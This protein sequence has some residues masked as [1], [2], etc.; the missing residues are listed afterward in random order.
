M[1]QPV[2]RW[3]IMG[4]VGTRVWHKTWPDVQ[5]PTFR[6]CVGRVVPLGPQGEIMRVNFFVDG[7]AQERWTC[8]SATSIDGGGARAASRG[9]D[10]CTSALL[11]T[12]NLG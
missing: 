11:Q 9:K 8:F 1:F 4:C 12:A 10:P 3:R 7:T 5:D 2:A 6:I